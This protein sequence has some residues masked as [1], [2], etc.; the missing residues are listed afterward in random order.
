[1]Q[2]SSY[3]ERRNSVLVLVMVDQSA[4]RLDTLQRTPLW[5]L[6]VL[7]TILPCSLFLNVSIYCFPEVDTGK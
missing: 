3:E 6:A 1:M 2:A 7:C 5:L 4:Y